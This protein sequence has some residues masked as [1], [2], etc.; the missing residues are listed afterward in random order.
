MGP[1]EAAAH[2]QSKDPSHRQ[3]DQRPQRGF[4]PSPSATPFRVT[5]KATVP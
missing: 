5:A 3:N 2:A 4:S 1:G